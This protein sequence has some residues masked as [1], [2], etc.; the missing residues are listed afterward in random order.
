[1]VVFFR[2]LAAALTQSRGTMTTSRPVISTATKR[3]QNGQ[4]LRL[5]FGRWLYRLPTTIYHAS[6]FAGKVAGTTPQR[7]QLTNIHHECIYF[8]NPAH[9]VRGGGRVLGMVA[10]EKITHPT[11]LTCKDGDT[12]K[13]GRLG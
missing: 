11:L 2:Q 7:S 9:H 6:R 10:L 5:D 3:L 12:A 8:Q 1:M 13:L 4:S